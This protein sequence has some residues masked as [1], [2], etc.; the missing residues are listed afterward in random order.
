MADVIPFGDGQFLIR[1]FAA[2]DIPD[3]IAFDRHYECLCRVAWKDRRSSQRECLVHRP[4]NRR[5]VFGIQTVDQLVLLLRTDFA[6]AELSRA[7]IKVAH[8]G[9]ELSEE[10]AKAR[11]RQT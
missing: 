8:W 3:R 1:L 10:E 6:Q 4:S 11:L 2:S 9:A 7:D 5:N